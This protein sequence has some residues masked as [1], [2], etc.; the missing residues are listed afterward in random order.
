MIVLT[1]TEMDLCDLPPPRRAHQE[2]ALLQDESPQNNDFLFSHS[3]V[4]ELFNFTSTFKRKSDFPLATRWLKDIAS[5]EDRK[6]L[7]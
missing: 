2:W 3:E 7:V 1:G 6:Y 5:L 4:M